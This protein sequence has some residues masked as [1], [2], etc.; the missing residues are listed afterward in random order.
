MAG[1]L[2]E[3][4]D[5]GRS[6]TEQTLQ[7]ASSSTELEELSSCE[8]RRS[9]TK[10]TLHVQIV[11]SSAELGELSCEKGRTSGWK[12]VAVND[13]KFHAG[14]I[15]KVS[16]SACAISPVSFHQYVRKGCFARW[17]DHSGKRSARG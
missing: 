1:E 8:K 2:S 5:K 15:G 9:E 12:T 16:G 17:L 10:Q 14:V 3:S 4:Y 13:G 6:G 11:S 7:I